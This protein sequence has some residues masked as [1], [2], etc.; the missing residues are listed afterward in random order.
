MSSEQR[1]P[2]KLL[3]AEQ[4]YDLWVRMLTGQITQVEAAAEAGVDRSV[5]ARLRAVA[6][7]GAVAALGSSKPGRRRQSQAEATE[8]AALRVEVE[9]LGRT[10]VEQAVE[11]AVL[12]G[13]TGWGMSGPVPARIDG[14]AKTA[15]LELI[16]DA[17][18]AGWTHSRACTVLGVDRRRA[19]RWTQRRAKGTL[20]DARPGG[21]AI[22]SLLSS[23]RDEILRL[24]EEWGDVDRSHRKLAHRG[25]YLGRVWVS[26]S[27]VD[28]G[29]FLQVTALHWP[30]RPALPEQSKHRGQTGVNGDPTNCGAGTAPSSR[31]VH[32]PSTSTRLLMSCPA[33]GSPPIS[34]Q[35]R[36]R[37]PLG[38]C[39]PKHCP[40]KGSSPKRPLPAS[41]TPTATCPTTMT[42]LCCWR[43]ATTDRRCAPVTPPSSWP[44]AQSPNTSAGAPHQLTR[45]GSSLCSAT[46]KTNTPSP[47]NARRPH[48]PHPRTR[49]HPQPLQLCAA[50]R[51]RRIRHPQRRTHRPRRP[52]PPSP[53]TRTPPSRPTTTR[54][55]PKPT[56]NMTNQPPPHTHQCDL[57]KPAIC[58]EE[59]DTPQRHINNPHRR[60]LHLKHRRHAIK[61]AGPRRRLRS[62]PDRVTARPRDA[63]IR[64]ERTVRRPQTVRV[65]RLHV[66]PPDGECQ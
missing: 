18:S 36:T 10:V 23:E 44:C 52:N 49:T 56:A 1:K 9:R 4:K 2:K 64:R 46:S 40:V 17:T 57:K 65:R 32:P 11:L 42:C 59:S 21:R 39:S 38:S 58:R 66:P 34:H 37:L 8:A 51:R 14:T 15:L 53:P 41:T 24:F 61:R 19:W 22:H 48:R 6:R 45:P 16:D 35:H 3:T 31:H 62:V 27:T 63:I 55:P 47:R 12:R 26:P 60:G 54:P 20:D 28:R 29:R 43:S 5:I 30:A 33:N 50:P 25:S 7:D 13:K